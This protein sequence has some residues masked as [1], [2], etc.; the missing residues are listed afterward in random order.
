[1]SAAC[2][3]APII[4]S[5]VAL[6]GCNSEDPDPRTEIGPHPDLP[7]IQQY[8]FAPMHIARVVGWKE[9]EKP[10][11]P[12]GLQV[13]ALATGLEHPRSLHVLPNGDILVVESRAPDL[14][15]IRRPKD[16][17]MGWVESMSTSAGE[18]QGSN[19]ITLL[20]VNDAGATEVRSVFLDH[21]SSP[22]GVALVGNDLYVADTDAIIRYAYRP[23]DTKITEPGTTLTPLP[24]GPIDHHWTKD[25]VASKDGSLLYV[26]VG[27]N[28]N[29]TEN[30]MEA[31]K[32]RASIWEVDRASG[33]FRLFATGLRNPNGLTLEPQTGALWTVVNER[34]ELGPNLVPD[35]MTSVKDG[36]FYGWP[37][38]YFG[39]HL[40]PRVM[41]QRPDLVASAIVPDYAL[42]S[43]VAP[44]GLVFYTGTNL[45]E[46]FRGGAFVGEHGSW[47]R[48]TLN[49]YKVAYIPF[50]GGH[51]NG[52]A[53]DVVTGFLNSQGEARGRPVGLAVD[54][55]GALLIADDVGNTVWRVFAASK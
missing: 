26:G 29:I 15:S 32:D 25:L 49:G 52:M 6:A 28:S 7:P 41:P 10:I 36:G 5:V 8:L 2:R 39:Q 53:E 16:V 1:M 11:V 17:I 31:E 9:G 43:H 14:H 33:R 34:D 35:Y 21:L 54:R 27:S 37:Y 40:D 3:L 20:R 47:N 38:S 22:F 50:E 4:L 51:P 23:G 30:G 44:L 24:G 19:R 13:Q 18:N 45:P 48:K 12:Q 46:K 55:T 42:S